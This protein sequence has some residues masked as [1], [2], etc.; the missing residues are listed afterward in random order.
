MTENGDRSSREL[1][2]DEIR[3][4][5]RFV[6]VTHEN[7]DG[8]AL[9]SLIAMQEILTALGKDSVMFIAAGEFPLPH[10]YRFLPLPGLV[11]SPPEDLAERTSL[12]LDCGNLDRGPGELEHPSTKIVNIDHHHDNTRFGTINHVVPDASCTAE[13]VWDLMHALDV[14]FTITIAE[15]LYVGLVTDTG[16]FMYENTG[17]RAH[18]MAAELIENGV[19]VHEIYR[20]VYEGVPYGKLALLARG[21]ASIERFDGGR[22][23]LS[24]LTTEDFT[25]SGAEESYSE[26]VIDHLRAVEGTA[27]AAL[28]RDRI[29]SGDD[30]RPRKVSLRS[31]DERVD[32]SRIARAQGG[33]G[34][35][36]AAGFSTALS[37]EELVSFLRGEIAA[38]L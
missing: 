25:E 28:V 6:V 22:L 21:L 35:R 26:G 1:A 24:R 16:R 37:W 11:T 2:L 4:G 30:E 27:V 12:Y 9:G 13:I 18:L 3:R 33:G 8:D 20:R 15:A 38:Q 19:D 14:E 32:V 23:T 10:E 36:G 5:E 29:S 34:H 7:P 17:V 31:S